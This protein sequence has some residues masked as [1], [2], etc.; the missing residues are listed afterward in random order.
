MEGM[1]IIKGLDNEQN[2]KLVYSTNEVQIGIADGNKPVYR[3]IVKIPMTYFVNVS[4]GYAN[5]AQ[6]IGVLTKEILFLNAYAYRASDGRTDPL[7]YSGNGTVS[8]W[9]TH[10]FTKNGETVL[11]FANKIEWGSAYTLIVTIEYTKL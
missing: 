4:S 10:T 9:L 7:P 11:N 8:T 2:S 1:F 5:L 3:K 6:G